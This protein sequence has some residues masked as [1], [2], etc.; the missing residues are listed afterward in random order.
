VYLLVYHAFRAVLA[1]LLKGMAGTTGLEPA[2]SAVTEY[3]ARDSPI[4]HDRQESR[5]SPLLMRFFNERSLSLCTSSH[6]CQF[7]LTR[8][9]HGRFVG[10]FVEEW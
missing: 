4:S 9:D 1:K 10:T 8:R 2:A 7:V 3:P 5:S 6:S